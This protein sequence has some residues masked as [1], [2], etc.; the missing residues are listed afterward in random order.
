MNTDMLNLLAG[1]AR[2]EY[3]ADLKGENLYGKDPSNAAHYVFYLAVRRGMLD[4]NTVPDKDAAIDMVTRAMTGAKAVAIE[5]ADPVTLRSQEDGPIN[6]N[7]F[8]AC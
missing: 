6:L 7:A 5:A 1:Q 4:L 2:A 3:D 8:Q